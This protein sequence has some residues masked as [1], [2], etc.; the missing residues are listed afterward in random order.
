MLHTK[1]VFQSAGFEFRGAAQRRLG[2]RSVQAMN[3]S[4]YS[5]NPAAFQ[6]WPSA[7]IRRVVKG[8]RRPSL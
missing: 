3:A 6:T 1:F 4:T 5:P 2:R 8:L 7:L